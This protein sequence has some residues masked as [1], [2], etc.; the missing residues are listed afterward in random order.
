MGKTLQEI[1]TDN[2]FPNRT[3]TAQETA[4]RIDK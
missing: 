3:L 1:G 2:K 4:M